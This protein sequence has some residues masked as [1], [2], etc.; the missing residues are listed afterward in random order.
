MIEIIPRDSS[1]ESVE[2][3]IK[4]FKKQCIKTGL[5]K[6]IRERRYYIKPSDKKREEKRAA[7]RRMD[8]ENRKNEDK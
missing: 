6:E 7:K 4:T 5:L 1:E 8:R 3:A 2:K